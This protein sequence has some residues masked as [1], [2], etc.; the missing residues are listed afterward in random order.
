[1]NSPK[2]FQGIDTVIL[3]VN[4]IQQ[5]KIWY[6]EKLGLTVLHEDEIQQLVVLDT[7]GATSLTLWATETPI[8]HNPEI[9]CY[10]IFGTANALEA[11]RRLQE[12]NVAVSD[13]VTDDTVTYFSFRD[14]D[15]NLLEVCQVS[16]GQTATP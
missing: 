13:I 7:N 16:V 15:N 6:M 12:M 4:H 11:H 2:F 8:R 9:T 3:R 14:L 1:M 5:A 10:P